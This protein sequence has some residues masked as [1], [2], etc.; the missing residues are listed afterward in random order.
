MVFLTNSYCLVRKIKKYW[1][2]DC[3]KSTKESIKSWIETAEKLSVTVCSIVLQKGL[4]LR[5]GQHCKN[6]AMVQNKIAATIRQYILS[7]TGSME[8][9]RDVL[10]KNINFLS[11]D[12]E[13]QNL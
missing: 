1:L 10:H 13:N 8:L 6:Y 3:Q 5:L 11:P 12:T 7:I 2:K 4:L 9:S